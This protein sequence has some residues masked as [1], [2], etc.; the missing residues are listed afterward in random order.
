MKILVIYRHYWP[1]ATPYAWILKTIAE[2][3]AADG[4]NVTVYSAQPSYND[5]GLKS[6]PR[7]ETIGGVR[8]LRR[9]LTPEKKTRLW[10][11][12]L[13]S[14]LFLA[15]SILHVLLSPR[16]DLVLVNTTPAILQGA[17]ARIIK[18]LR[19]IPYIYHCQD[20]HPEA[21]L[22]GGKFKPGILY[23]VLEWLDRMTVQDAATVVVLS[24]DMEGTLRERG[25]SVANVA[26]INNLII[27]EVKNDDVIIPTQ[28]E[29][30]PGL[31]RAIFAGNL[32]HFQGLETI[33]EAA[34]LL[35]DHSEIE[36]LFLGNGLAKPF[37][38]E[39]AGDLV[40]KTVLFHDFVPMD[41]ACKVLESADVGIVCLQNNVFKVAFPSKTM[42]LLNAGCPL[43]L[44]VEP[45]SS[46]SKFVV[47]EKLGRTCPP[48][49]P[50]IVADMICDIASAKEVWRKERERI[51]L[52]AENN[53]GQEVILQKWSHLV[54]GLLPGEGRGRR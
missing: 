31:F 12:I 27:N 20:L 26:I 45:E 9:S 54:N 29:P 47:E 35:A 46:L 17:T 28:L 34:L 2:R 18:I 48:G 4:H 8:I 39:K 42:M 6:C 50:Q 37:L 22:Y 1:D 19:G 49:D 51:R 38:E 52:V 10:T 43:L 44:V 25:L 23:R 24:P 41:I 3:L 11:R 33:I 7:Q 40:G 30:K 15:G 36:F 32:G 5:I 14:L 21:G 53:F 16:Y 13:N